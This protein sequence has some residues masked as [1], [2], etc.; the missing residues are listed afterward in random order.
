MKKMFNKCIC[1]TLCVLLLAC[2]PSKISVR[3]PEQFQG[4][5]VMHYP[6]IARMEIEPEKI[7]HVYKD[8]RCDIYKDCEVLA[9]NN[10]LI[11]RE[12]DGIFEPIYHHKVTFGMASIT[13]TGYPYVYK[14]FREV[15]QAD[16]ELL[17]SPGSTWIPV[18]TN[19]RPYITNDTKTPLWQV[20]ITSVALSTL[21]IAIAVK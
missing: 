6:M 20:I 4:T 1:L 3:E 2:F 9:Y 21:I 5:A 15:T 10:A 18:Q 8:S 16:K 12:I 17:S 11:E 19:N 14:E 13:V 7:S